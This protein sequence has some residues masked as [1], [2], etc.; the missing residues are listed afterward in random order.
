M[1]SGK[2]RTGGC[3]GLRPGHSAGATGTLV[4]TLCILSEGRGPCLI[5]LRVARQLRGPDILAEDTKHCSCGGVSLSG[6]RFPHMTV[7]LCLGLSFPM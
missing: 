6:P 7:Y 1:E 5:D 4:L 2:E 3:G